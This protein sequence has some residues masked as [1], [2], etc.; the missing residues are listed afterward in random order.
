MTYLHPEP[1]TDPP[2]YVDY[3]ELADLR[4]AAELQ[5]WEEERDMS[6]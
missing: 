5:R 2:E 6:L 3:D 1:P 4:E